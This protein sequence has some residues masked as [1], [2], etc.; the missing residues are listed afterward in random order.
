MHAECRVT[1]CG[2]TNAGDPTV[3]A[4]SRQLGHTVG[5]ADRRIDNASPAQYL[6]ERR[7]RVRSRHRRVAAPGVG[8][9]QRRRRSLSEALPVRCRA[10][11]PASTRGPRP[12]AE[13]RAAAAAPE[14]ERQGGLDVGHGQAGEQ[15]EREPGEPRVL[16]E[17]EMIRDARAEHGSGALAGALAQPLQHRRPAKARAR[18]RRC[19]PSSS[20]RPRGCARALRGSAPGT[21]ED[22]RGGRRCRR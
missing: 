18:R 16:G 15:G 1:E 10:R 8:E 19:A 9:R 20:S 5:I 22:G 11:P 14:G 4:E 12:S 21:G 7:V 6:P 17:K 2:G 13:S 3:G